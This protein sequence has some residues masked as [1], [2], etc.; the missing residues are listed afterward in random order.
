MVWNAINENLHTDVIFRYNIVPY[1]LC[2]TYRCIRI[3]LVQSTYLNSG[4]IYISDILYLVFIENMLVETRFSNAIHI[5]QVRIHKWLEVNNT[6]RLIFNSITFFELH[7]TTPLG[8]ISNF[9]L[10][11]LLFT[12]VSKIIL[13]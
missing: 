12:L 5:N 8:P 3:N 9:I 4:Q 10:S 13:S 7:K 6:T 11:F 2:F 1:K